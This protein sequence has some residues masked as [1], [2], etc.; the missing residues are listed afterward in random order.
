MNEKKTE[1]LKKMKLNRW[2][3]RLQKSNILQRTI[4]KSLIDTKNQKVVKHTKEQV[5]YILKNWRIRTSKWNKH[6]VN[7]MLKFRKQLEIIEEDWAVLDSWDEFEV[8]SALLELLE[9]ILLWSDSCKDPPNKISFPKGRF[10]KGWDKLKE[11]YGM[12]ILEPYKGEMLETGGEYKGEICDAL[13]DWKEM[14]KKCSKGN[15]TNKNW[16]RFIMIYG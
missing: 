10:K 13:C 11:R 12:K 16:P 3:F 8:S 2:L 1:V 14:L 5:W 6:Q 15:G 9:N 7:E 4:R